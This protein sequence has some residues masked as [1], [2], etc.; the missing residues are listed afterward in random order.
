MHTALIAALCCALTPA[1]PPVSQGWTDTALIDVDDDWSRI[2]WVV[3]HRGDGLAGSPGTDPRLIVSDGSATPVDVAANRADPEAIGLAA[4]VAEFE[5]ANPVVAIRGSATASAPHLV[6]ALDTRGRAGIAA[7]LAVRDVDASA[8][9]A[10]ES[11]AVQFRLGTAGD[12]ANLPGGYVADATDGARAGR[13]TRM[14]AVLP[15]AA[16]GQPLV[17]LRVI[18]T[19]AAGR[20][21]WV[22]IDDIEITAARTT[23]DCDALGT[24][25]D[26]IGA[27]TETGDRG[28]AARTFGPDPCS[29][30]PSPAPGPPSSPVPGPDPAPR[31]R[32]DRPRTA[33]P[34]LTE[35]AL[36]PACFRA[37]RRGP[38]IRMRGKSG[39]ALRFRLSK[40][41]LV[42]FRVGPGDERRRFQVRGRRGLNRLRFTGRVRG[43][44]LPDGAYTLSAVAVDGAGRSA[45]VAVVRFRVGAPVAQPSRGPR[46]VDRVIRD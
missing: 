6:M 7:R 1:Q 4:G 32:P 17:Q 18:T 25:A 19:N 9:D 3:G 23:G 37:A 20:D 14:R 46:Y 43:R 2:P 36:A 45:A 41:A 44:A 35:L 39:A 31:P 10:V 28:F 5:L 42:R 22:G 8:T 33:P 30:D 15:A 27:T 13:I 29:P 40:A 16:D 24:D 21:E 26:R 11:V 34:A 38:A 12:F